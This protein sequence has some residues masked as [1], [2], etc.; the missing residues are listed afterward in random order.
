M[1]N[2]SGH[3]QGTIVLEFRK[4]TKMSLNR[5]LNLM[6]HQLKSSVDGP[7]NF[8]PIP[9]HMKLY[10]GKINKIIQ[11]SVG[12]IVMNLKLSCSRT[13]NENGEKYGHIALQGTGSLGSLDLQFSLTLMENFKWA[14]KEDLTQIKWQQLSMKLPPTHLSLDAMEGKYSLSYYEQMARWE[15]SVNIDTKIADIIK[16]RGTQQVQVEGMYGP[17]TRPR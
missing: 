9:D 1:E 2:K 13:T 17:Q 14:T 15:N 12:L 11:T 6:G 5:F 4:T 3:L 10:Q 16:K 7:I 8:R